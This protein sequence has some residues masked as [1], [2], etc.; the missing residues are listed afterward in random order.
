MFSFVFFTNG[1][2]VKDIVEIQIFHNFYFCCHCFTLSR[3]TVQVLFCAK[4]GHTARLCVC[5]L[6]II[7]K[8]FINTIMVSSV[9]SNSQQQFLSIF[10]HNKI[11]IQICRGTL[12]V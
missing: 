6:I 11:N 2:K 8:V 9:S 1:M 7:M 3:P 12:M 10:N 5:V 4:R